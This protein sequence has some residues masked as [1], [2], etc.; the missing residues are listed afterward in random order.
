MRPGPHY[1][2]RTELSLLSC[3]ETGFYWARLERGKGSALMI[4]LLA[5]AYLQD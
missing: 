2:K 3:G 5:F 4:D 1:W